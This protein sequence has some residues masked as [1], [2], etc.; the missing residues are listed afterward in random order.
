MNLR[1]LSVIFAAI[2]TLGLGA[3]ASTPKADAAA[4]EVAA[5]CA[6][7]KKRVAILR[8]G[9]TGKYGAL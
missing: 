7:P 5:S 1:T 2:L 4:E 6:G 8:F 3:C 9:G